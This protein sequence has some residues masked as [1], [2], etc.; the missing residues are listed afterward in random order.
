MGFAVVGPNRFLGSGHPDFQKDGDLPPLLGLIGS[1]DAGETWKSVSL[2][3]KAD[4]HVLESSGS[5]IYGYDSSGDR[6]MVSADAGK[7][8]DERRTP[9]SLLSLAIDPAD[10]LHVVASGERSMYASV[11]GGRTWKKLASKAGL[12][13]W[14]AENRLYVIEADG[15]VLLSDNGGADWSASGDLEEQPGAFEAE[16]SRDLYAALHDGTVK[17]SI[18]G[19]ATWEV[20]A[21]P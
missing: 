14:P 4:F 12:L 10:S 15:A 17:R 18:D 19:G 13:A 20:R 7:S 1:N 8:W 5:R 11:N 16:G 6:L 9:E 3:G 21:R 2:L